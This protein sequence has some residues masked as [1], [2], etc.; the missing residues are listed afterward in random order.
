MIRN[1]DGTWMM[2]IQV[3]D[4]LLYSSAK[5]NRPAAGMYSVV[6]ARGNDLCRDDTSPLL[7][8]CQADDEKDMRDR[9]KS[10]VASSGSCAAA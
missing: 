2:E 6:I 4:L 9:E 5:A 3:G 8:L 7:F 1:G 10:S